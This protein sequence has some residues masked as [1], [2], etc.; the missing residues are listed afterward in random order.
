[1]PFARRS[2]EVCVKTFTP[3]HRSTPPDSRCAEC[4][5]AST[6]IRVGANWNDFK[7]GDP[8][9]KAPAAETHAASRGDD[10]KAPL[11]QAVFDIETW[12]LDR[13]WGVMMAACVMVHSGG[14]PQFYEFDL[15]QG[16]SWPNKRSD[17]SWLA[18]Q[19]ISV[20]DKCDVLYAHNGENFDI[21]WLRT[22]ALK[23]HLPFNEKK[24]IDPAK[25]GWAKYRVGR[26]S[27]SCLAEFLF[28]DDQSIRKMPVPPDVWRFAI[29]DNDEEAWRTLRERCK[30]DVM[31]LNAVAGRVTRDVGLINFRGSAF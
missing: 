25:I 7:P 23:Y 9:E 3:R 8:V 17:D 10:F 13:G 5:D 16:P 4:R 29:L 28:P 15:T 27:L 31:V 21:R 26:N 11:T 12:G 14:A 2:C 24:L 6:R 18:A 1:L 19:V 30:S 22:L 20:L